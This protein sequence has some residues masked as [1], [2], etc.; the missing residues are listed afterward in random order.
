[1]CVLQLLSKGSRRDRL[2]AKFVESE[3]EKVDRLMEICFR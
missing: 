1:M 2:A 3:Y